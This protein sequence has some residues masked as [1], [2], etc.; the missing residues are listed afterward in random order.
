[1]S[2]DP[3]SLAAA[4]QQKLDPLLD[5]T[6]WAAEEIDAAAQRHPSSAARIQRSFLLLRPTH[7]LLHTE[8]MLRPHCR[9]LL[10][11]VA[12]G[13][14]TRPGTAAECCLAL[15]QTS[16]L[17]PLRA[18]AIGLYA[19]MWRLA[20]LPPGVL[21]EASDH[22]EALHGELIDEHEAWLRRQLRQSWRILPPPGTP[23]Q[24]PLG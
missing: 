23:S 7:P 11:R 12:R 20:G 16:L 24:P 14:D 22:Y 15:C 4:I 1:V 19:R 5:A 21:G 9:E 10:D 13:E 2:L 18:S 3:A 17:A 6:T 8:V